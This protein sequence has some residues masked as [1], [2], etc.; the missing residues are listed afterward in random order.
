MSTQ[1]ETDLDPR[2]EALLGAPEGG[3][4]GAAS[5][6]GFLEALLQARP[7][8]RVWLDPALVAAWEARIRAAGGQV[9]VLASGGQELLDG[10]LEAAGGGA[11]G[12]QVWFDLGRRSSLDPSMT[13][14][15][16]ARGGTRERAPLAVLLRDDAPG[17]SRTHRL[18][19][20][21]PAPVLLLRESATGA[22]ALGAPGLLADLQIH[23][24]ATVR[25]LPSTFAAPGPRRRL[26]ALDVDGV[27]IEPGRAFH[28]AVAQALADLA[29]AMPWSDDLFQAFKRAGGFNNDFRLA[30]GALALEE[31]EGVAAI[32]GY[33]GRGLPHL[34][35]RIEELEPRCRT[36]VEKH[37]ARTR[38]LEQPLLVRGDLEGFPG[39]VA[40][41]TG[42]P[43]D[44]LLMGFQVL[45]FSLPAA[46]DR[47][48][49]LR[50]PRPEGLIQLADAYRATDVVFVGDTLDDAAALRGARGLCPGVAWT[51]AAVGPDRARITVPGDLEA[52]RLVDLLP[53]LKAGDWS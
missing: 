52:E 31:T 29:P 34:A 21:Q 46:C 7:P 6:D 51:F 47:A 16:L 11:T 35:A 37:Y 42:R 50:K 48:P 4:L 18:A 1:P 5:L 49:H 36:R 12:D 22:Y 2:A 25:P 20:D 53:R 44:E 27:L 24:G 43:P 33:E 17:R 10:L 14:T 26:L 13:E 41:F 9:Q 38:F 28:E 23:L 19:V 40:I 15:F 30:A 8:E 3:A 39:D 32:Q 45:G